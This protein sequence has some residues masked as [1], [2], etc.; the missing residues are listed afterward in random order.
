MAKVQPN[1]SAAEYNSSSND[2]EDVIMGMKYASLAITDDKEG[3]L[4]NIG[5]LN[6]WH[7]QALKIITGGEEESHKPLTYLL[8]E[9]LDLECDAII[10]ISGLTKGGHFLDTQGYIAHND[11]VI[12]LAF[13]CTTSIFGKSIKHETSA[14]AVDLL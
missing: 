3:T 12:V 9:H 7:I 11:E 2:V 10:D 4:K 1:V 13:R 6:P 8:K 14:L 5:K